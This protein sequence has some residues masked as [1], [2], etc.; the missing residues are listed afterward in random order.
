MSGAAPR[1]RGAPSGSRG[2]SSASV[3]PAS[4]ACDPGCRCRSPAARS[5]K[6]GSDAWFVSTRPTPGDCPGR[7][8]EW[9]TP[10]RAPLAV[11][12]TSPSS[13]R[14]STLTSVETPDVRLAADRRPVVGDRGDVA[15][16]DVAAAAAVAQ[17]QAVAGAGPHDGVAQ[18]RRDG[19]A[20][21]LRAVARVGHQLE[22]LADGALE[23]QRVVAGA[24]GVEGQVPDDAALAEGEERAGRRA[25]A[26]EARPRLP[27]LALEGDRDVDVDRLVD[28]VL[29]GPQDHAVAVAGVV[30]RVTQA[31]GVGGRA[32]VAAVGHGRVR[33]EIRGVSA[34]RRSEKPT[35]DQAP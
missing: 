25:G 22:V 32:V 31:A 30:E 29:A 3:V 23:G 5:A 14:A 6:S 24:G 19:R 28:V 21:E 17:L 20:V 34:R 2:P 15:Q 18:D 9:E 11:A 26:H 16:G 7:R 33:P 12:F 1:R 35:E 10:Q 4:T 8:L 27:G 13:P